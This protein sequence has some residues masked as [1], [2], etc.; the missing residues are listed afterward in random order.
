MIGNSIALRDI[1]IP[2]F[3]GFRIEENSELN[4]SLDHSGI[5]SPI[6]IDGRDKLIDG[7]KRIVWARQHEVD[8]VKVSRLPA[9]SDA[10]ILRMNLELNAEG[11]SSAE[12]S[13][14][15]YFLFRH[16]FLDNFFRKHV[17]KITKSNLSYNQLKIVSSIYYLSDETRKILHILNYP[18]LKLYHLMKFETIYL[19]KFITDAYKCRL[20][21]N[22]I[23][24]GFENLFYGSK[25][26]NT[27][28]EKGIKL[29]KNEIMLQGNR[30]EHI[31]KWLGN[32]RY[33]AKSLCNEK[34]ERIFKSLP[35][36]INV[37]WDRNLEKS[38]MELRIKINS[39]TDMKKTMEVLS[40]LMKSDLIETF[41]KVTQ[42]CEFF[43]SDHLTL[44]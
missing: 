27:G 33:P 22:E 21:M 4:T 31:K 37:I 1:I 9:L 26:R 28:L 17:N 40:G 41:R 30:R 44:D 36:D 35:P 19:D 7:R 16:N 38:E 6:I 8:E 18:F 13:L 25:L 34:M 3:L 39:K 12:A 14:L 20:N 32:F 2:D 10:S 43:S 24:E 42:E 15:L 5:I 29:F 23:Y 11:L